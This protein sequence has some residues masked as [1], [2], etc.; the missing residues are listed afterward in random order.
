M[1]EQAYTIRELK[2]E[3]LRPDLLGD[4]NRDQRVTE[5]L[6]KQADGSWA[7]VAVDF[8]EH[9]DAEKKRH[10][11]T[12]YFADC[13]A[14]GGVVLAATDAEGQVVGFASVEGEPMGGRGQYRNLK[15][16]HVSLPWRGKGLGRALFQRAAD[17][18]RELGAEKLYISASSAVETQAF[19]LRVG[20]VD[21]EEVDPALFQLEPYDRHMEYVL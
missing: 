5:Q 4:F 14:S 20:C 7:P 6:R 11:A 10:V 16:L 3:D 9:W 8:T 1:K 12:K 13:M 19:Y 17:R 18:T 2:K 15:Y 21:A